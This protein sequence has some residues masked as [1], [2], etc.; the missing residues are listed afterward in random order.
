[1]IS[2][3]KEVSS[4][5]GGVMWK[6]DLSKKVNIKDSPLEALSRDNLAGTDMGYSIVKAFIEKHPHNEW[7]L[8]IYDMLSQSNIE[9][10]CAVSEI[11]KIVSFIYKTEHAAP[12]SFIAENPLSESYVVGMSCTR[13]RLRIPGIYSAKDGKLVDLLGD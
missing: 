6:P 11:P 3:Y 1:M 7:T 8:S 2:D 9:I 4:S 5:F 13:G 12:I 10:A